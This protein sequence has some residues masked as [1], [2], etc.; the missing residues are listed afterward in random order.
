M[1][2]SE[3]RQCCVIAFETRLISRADRDVC[4]AE[5]DRLEPG[6]D[7]ECVLVRRGLVT[8]EQF[9]T[10]LGRLSSARTLHVSE[11]A[12]SGA[13]E[14]PEVEGYEVSESIG[15]GAMGSVWRAVQLSTRRAV[16]LKLMGVGAF[17][18]GSARVRFEREV[19]LSARLTHPHI[20]QVY[21]SGLRRGVY[22]YAM[23]LIDGMHLD[24]HVEQ[25]GL[26]QRHVLE[27][28]RS[29]C[30]A[31]QHAH[32]RGVIHRDL[33]PSNILVSP[34]GQP[35]VVD[36]GLAKAYREGDDA[37]VSV[38]GAQSG[39]PAFMSPEQASGQ[40]GRIDTRTD[41]YS[42]GIILY[43][44]LTGEMPHDLSGSTFT[45]MRR[46]AE[47]EPRRPR[48]VCKDVDR[49]LEALLLKALAHEPDD[50]YDTAGDL[51][52]D[53]DNYLTGEPLAAKAPTTLY[54][55]RKRLRKYRV[56]VAIAA[57]VA[58]ALI[59]MAVWAYVRVSLERTHALQEA[60]FANIGFAEA[61][62]DE[63]HVAQ[64]ERLLDRCSPPLRH[65]EWRWLKHLCHL[66]LATVRAHATQ[67]WAVAVS[68]D[69]TRIA[70]GGADGLIKLWDAKT[71]RELRTLEGHTEAVR[72]VAFSPDGTRLASGGGD[73]T[74]RLWRLGGQHKP[75]VLRGHK[76]LTGLT[77]ADGR[78]IRVS[79]Y[80]VAFSP[81]GA[82]L[83]S[84]G[85][86]GDHTVKVWDAATGKELLTLEGH[87]KSVL[88]VA[89]SHD[90]R[91]IA[92]ADSEDM[93][94]VW[95]AA[96]GKEIPTPLADAG[97]AVAF[98]PNGK[99][100]ATGTK[101]GQ[102]VLRDAQTF[103]EVARVKAHRD[104]VL[105]LVYSRDGTSFA[106]GGR[107]NLVKAWHAGTG[108]E[109]ATFMGHSGIVRAVAFLPGGRRLVSASADGTIKLW[110]RE[111]RA[112]R[113]ALAGHN[114]SV[115]DAV[116]SPDGSRLISASL[117]G[118]LRVWDLASAAVVMTLGKHADEVW[119][120]ALSPDGSRI[121]SLSKDGTVKGWDA[122]T[123]RELVSVAGE[124]AYFGSI[125]FGPDGTR[126]IG[127]GFGRRLKVWDAASGRELATI[128]ADKGLFSPDGTLIAT[129]AYGDPI[130]LWDAKTGAE[131]RSIP[132]PEGDIAV[133]LAFSPDGAWLASG[134]FT[135]TVRLWDVRTGREA[136]TLAGHTDAAHS[137]AFSP[138]GRRIATA[139][140]DGTVK[141]WDAATGRELL[142]L[143]G[144]TEW[145]N[146]VVF[147]PNG[148][149]I[150][151]GGPDN[152][153]VIREATP[154]RGAKP[155]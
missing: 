145:P 76:E 79:V 35:H 142:T 94:K 140:R 62:L 130:K 63:G 48:E 64:A 116:F 9:A 88:A 86:F 149:R 132:Q 136:R 58:L 49:E 125:A 148:T 108:R 56:P 55:L 37:N 12:P 75:L 117:D 102:V 14:L 87:G 113:L 89:F 143:A 109:A 119:S 77:R 26:G 72:C 111:S 124:K 100:L 59:A 120:V 20:A 51:A 153:I 154:T 85:G 107:D 13:R 31:V 6:A 30:E 5:L 138:D 74:V 3:Q 41:V 68:P 50:R 93:V 45:V 18:S 126:L 2:V 105:A 103:D 47:E 1:I 57:A 38:D 99:H 106:T 114:K 129:L 128:Q 73:G 21:D 139:S 46:I 60:Y 155:R 84:A 27:L 70:T 80:A 61:K 134:G 141:L 54:F 147:S 90:G 33:K 42:L 34:D 82:R 95:D 28:M 69:G 71:L 36:F 10:I 151:C 16:A 7:S 104:S 40:V 133:V 39:T 123:G 110:D 144:N 25:H 11:A 115:A 98:S 66:D 24:A 52:D 97:Q 43:R 150:A 96:T 118:T 137:I 146:F 121:A 135:G 17:V 101:D 53:I 32:Q 67:V 15:E 92:S 65:W 122:K 83:A 8:P 131:L 152:T 4:L 112:R 81:D 23:E 78:S 19:E 22:F 127:G 44:L 29:V 91:R